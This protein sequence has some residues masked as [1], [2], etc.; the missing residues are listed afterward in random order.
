MGHNIS[1]IQNK[2]IGT[3]TAQGHSC[4]PLDVDA[5]GCSA[6]DVDGS[7]SGAWTAVSTSLINE[8]DA[9]GDT[10]LYISMEPVSI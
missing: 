10:Y 4:S 2:Y 3:L 9:G 7:G 5:D 1:S 8:G 6:S